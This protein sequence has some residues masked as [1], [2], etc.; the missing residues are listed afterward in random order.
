MRRKKHIGTVIRAALLLAF[1]ALPIS[2]SAQAAPPPGPKAQSPVQ[3]PP[4]SRQAVL[5]DT[6]HLLQLARELKASVDKTRRDELSMQVIREADE[7]EKL[8]RS[9]KA[10]I[11]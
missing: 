7:I 4:D 11:R 6:D 8:A 5:S 3:G 9:T 1:C 2:A 10:R